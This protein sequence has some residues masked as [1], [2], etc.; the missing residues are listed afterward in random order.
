MLS[1]FVKVINILQARLKSPT[2]EN[3]SKLQILVRVGFELRNT[4]YFKMAAN[5]LFFCLHVH[6]PS[7]PHFHFKILL[8]FIHVGEAMRAN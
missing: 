3:A 7:L 1:K 4:P 8:F 2:Q 6:G 5:K